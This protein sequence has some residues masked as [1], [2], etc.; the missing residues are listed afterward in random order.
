MLH[1]SFPSLSL[2]SSQRTELGDRL[3]L[4]NLT[5]R[6]SAGRYRRDL[7]FAPTSAL[8]GTA[9]AVG[10]ESGLGCHSIAISEGT[11]IEGTRL[12][13]GHLWLN[14]KAKPQ[15]GSRRSRKPALK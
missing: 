1:T 2:S 13:V 8:L 3:L 15:S 4:P 5:R 9:L 7:D 11:M 6:S 14:P 12:G 10:V